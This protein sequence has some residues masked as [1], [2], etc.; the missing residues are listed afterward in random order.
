M[1][2]VQ[3]AMLSPLF[4]MDSWTKCLKYYIFL[5]LLRNFKIFHPFLYEVFW[6]DN[7]IYIFDYV[8]MNSVL[9]SKDE[10]SFEY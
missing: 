6:I 10:F 8:K 3:N 4:H 2:H 1:F 5:S 9:S 7:I